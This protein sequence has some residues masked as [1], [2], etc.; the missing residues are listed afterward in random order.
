MAVFPIPP[1]PTNV[2]DWDRSTKLNRSS[3]M[4]SRPKKFAGARGRGGD[5]ERR[6][7]AYILAA[8]E[9]VV[10]KLASEASCLDGWGVIRV[11]ILVLTIVN[12]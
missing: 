9:V 8:F 5:G 4:T 6:F 10:V 2:A 7:M 1:A 12:E 11:D 3:T